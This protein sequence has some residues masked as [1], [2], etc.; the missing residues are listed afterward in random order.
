MASGMPNRAMMGTAFEI[1]DD[2][3]MDLDSAIGWLAERSYGRIALLGVSMGAVKVVYYQAHV[4]DPRVAAV[5]AVSPVRLSCSYYLTTEAA[6][7]YQRYYR[8]AQELTQSGHPEALINVVED[9][10]PGQGIFGAQAYLE[11]Y[12]SGLSSSYLA[13]SPLYQDR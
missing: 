9:I 10:V 13:P 2:C 12:G 3:R 4:Q 5:I 1:L 6:S 11:K 8:Q 7:D